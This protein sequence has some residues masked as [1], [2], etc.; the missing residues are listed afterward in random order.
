MDHDPTFPTVDELFPL[1]SSAV[2][3]SNRPGT[4]ASKYSSNYDRIVANTELA[5]PDNP[6]S[7]WLWTGKT[8]RNGYGAF[9]V[10]VDGKHKTLSTHREVL[11]ELGIDLQDDHEP[12][13]LCYTPGCSNPDHLEPKTRRDNLLNR[14]KLK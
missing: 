5:V 6:Q 3:R 9:N 1:P 7:C 11:K 2:K 13:H 10:R 8:R 14:R 4:F 12:D